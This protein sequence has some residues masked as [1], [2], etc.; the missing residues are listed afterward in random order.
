MNN[1][2]QYNRDKISSDAMLSGFQYAI[3]N[4][5]VL[6]ETLW[7]RRQPCFTLYQRPPGQAQPSTSLAQVER[8]LATHC[9]ERRASLEWLA[10]PAPVLSERHVPNV[11]ASDFTRSNTNTST[12]AHLVSDSMHLTESSG[13]YQSQL[14]GQPN[15][16]TDFGPPAQENRTLKSQ[17]RRMG[18]NNQNVAPFVK[19]SSTFKNDST[20]EVT[21]LYDDDD[22][23]YD[24]LI[25]QLDV[26]QLVAQSQSNNS[27]P[28]A[29]S[30][31]NS[32]TRNNSGASWNNGTSFQQSNNYQH[33]G[34]DSAGENDT[35]TFGNN[36][37]QGNA[38]YGSNS[39]E[40]GD[41]G[42]ASS[43]SRSYN[44]SIFGQT[45][46]INQQQPSHACAPCCPGH[47]VPCRVLTANTSAN[48]GRQFYKCALP[49]GEQCDYFE[50]TDGQESNTNNSPPTG[51]PIEYDPSDVKDMIRENRFKF[52]HQSFRPGQ[53]EVIAHAIRGRDVFVLMPTGGGKSLCYQLPAWCTPGLSVV[54]SPLLSLIQDQVQSLT[55]L[56]VQAVHLSSA[57][58]YETEQREI[59]QRLFETNDHDGVK[60]LYIT[61][62]K[63]NNSTVI[64]NILQRLNSKQLISRF[65]VDEAHC[66]SDWGHE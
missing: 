7:T 23:D 30:N 15:T 18:G 36:F 3:S 55:K 31:Y 66:L 29:Q 58:D 64:R 39:Y 49:E 41:N 11:N 45:S 32:T 65:V 25:A 26:D 14:H 33:H 13:R 21:A 46:D 12:P 56:G 24:A 8:L 42:D 51:A 60:M 52:G 57:Q 6:G 37:A 63:L 16:H 35:S 59:T 38:A 43:F 61:P 10:Q 1:N 53:K 34:Y 4:G 40:E 27:K 5:I 54:V 47:G 48:Q 62:E 20:S 9:P 44:D 17:N 50:W 22:D 19:N 28:F 2:L